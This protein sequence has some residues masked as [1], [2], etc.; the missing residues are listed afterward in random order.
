MPPLWRDS[1]A[2]NQLVQH[3]ALATVWGHGPLY[4]LAARVPLYLGYALE[5][6]HGPV[7]P[8]TG[9][10]L[11][12]SGLTNTGILLLIV[13]QHLGLCAAALVFIRASTGRFFLR[14]IFAAAFASVP[15]FYTFAHCVGSETLSMILL[16]LFA[17]AGL[18][19]VRAPGEISFRGYYLFALLLYALL[20]TRYV[21]FVLVGV[22]PAAFLL[23]ALRGPAR[24]KLT[25]AFLTLAIGFVSIVLARQTMSDLAHWRKFEYHSRPGFTFLWRLRFLTALPAVERAEVLDRVATRLKTDDARKIL[26]LLRNSAGDEAAM[27]PI[28]F[29]D[30]IPAALF[31]PET[32][33]KGSL[34]VR[35]QDDAMNEIA[36]GFLSPPTAPQWR[37]AWSDFARA[38]GWPCG[39]VVRYLFE[40]TAYILPRLDEMPEMARLRTFRD[41]TPAALARIPEENAYLRL[42][43][44]VPLDFLLALSASGIVIALLRGRRVAL[45]SAALLGAGGA[46]VFSTCLV[47]AMIQR[48]TL[49]LW[50][51]AFLALALSLGALVE[52][53]PSA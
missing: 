38:R 15:I 52:R 26:A 42:W 23:S 18:Q 41:T 14:L 30:R 39:E 37:S 47:G 19:L 45:Y 27:Q 13:A 20:L 33:V 32:K 11:G 31:P 6:M 12:N 35:R 3:P 1:D 24:A 10:F 51:L 5:R 50:E 2:Y 7:L 29:Y 53:E 16:L 34:R 9:K 43:R 28:A 44:N 25:A 40:T 46:M 21:N 4:C 48:Y 36:R 8:E 17:T 22:L 49:P